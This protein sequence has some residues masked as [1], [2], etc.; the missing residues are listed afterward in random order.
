VIERIARRAGVHVRVDDRRH[1]RLAGEADTRGA[2]RRLDRSRRADLR[3]AVVLHEEARVLDH[4][5][6]ADDDAAAFEDG[7]AIAR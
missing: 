3:D 5:A 4:L 7:D 1:H 6:V 2:G